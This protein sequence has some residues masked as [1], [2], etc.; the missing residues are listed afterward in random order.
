M[1]EIAGILRVDKPEGPTSHDV[2]A[3]A[4]R[5]LRTRRVG[6]TGTLDPFASGL[7]LLCLGSS[8]RL[9]E[10]LGPLPKSYT[11]TMRL[12]SATTSDDATGEVISSA[13]ASAVTREAVRRRSARSSAISSSSR[14]SSPRRRWAASGCTRPRAVA[15]SSSALPPG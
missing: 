15:S 10:Y 6:H 3:M 12:G 7:L 14:P 9:A 2:V 4:R 11:A 8:T 1:S 5:A 13:D